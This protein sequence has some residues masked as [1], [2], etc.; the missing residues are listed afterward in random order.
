M[1]PNKG[2]RE[3]G[4]ILVG[5]VVGTTIKDRGVVRGEDKWSFGRGG[6]F[7]VGGVTTSQRIRPLLQFMIKM[8]WGLI[9]SFGRE[10]HIARMYP[11]VHGWERRML[12]D[13]DVQ[14]N[15]EKDYVSDGDSAKALSTGEEKGQGGLCHERR[16]SGVDLPHPYGEK[17]HLFK[18]CPTLAGSKVIRERMICQRCDFRHRLGLKMDR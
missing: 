15:D 6:V 5:D 18:D 10:G 12:L 14:R 17:Y 3:D 8:D 9:Q 1:G 16:I 7:V 4:T 11:G 13:D 2:G